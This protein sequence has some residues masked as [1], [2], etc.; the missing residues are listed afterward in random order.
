MSTA[1]TFATVLLLPV[2]QAA[3]IVGATIAVN[4]VIA[5]FRRASTT[6]EKP[7]LGTIAL[8][9]LFNGGQGYLSILAAGL[10]LS[11]AGTSAYGQLRPIDALVIVAA[12]VAMYTTNVVLVSAA[13]ALG[14]S[15]NLL[16]VIRN[17]H[18]LVV[19]QFASLYLVG[20]AAAFAAVSLPWLLVLS[21]AGALL[22]Y[23]SWKQR[24]ELRRES[25][26][27]LERMADEVD[28]RD[29]YTYQHSQRVAK[30][31][32]EIASQLRLSRAEIELIELAAK[33]HDIGKIRIPDSILLKA[34]K[35]T[36]EERRVMETH[37]RL[38]F[39]ILR[40]FS[41][42]AKV[43]DLVLTH[44]ERYDGLGYPNGTVGRRQ[45][46]IAQVIP[47]VDS[48]DAMTSNRAYRAAKSWEAA[49]EELR[50]GSGSQW[51]P[52][53]VEAAVAVLQQERSVA[54]ASLT[55]VPIGA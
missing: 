14:T 25:V 23:R 37:P 31:S 38:G 46:L 2:W 48:F 27:A 52:K 13:I 18:K 9:L 15:R 29:P 35:L 51:N 33:V 49:L 32:R 4:V 39:Q 21:V 24:M 45:L 53:V 19:G 10:V 50:H 54:A 41:E 17:S 6:R 26:R 22:V 12:A 43:L 30:Y 44:H 5:S 1:V 40:P 47:V 8:L 34:G 28:R 3:A 20:A 42:Y 11:S 55:A 36:G 16:S 7:P